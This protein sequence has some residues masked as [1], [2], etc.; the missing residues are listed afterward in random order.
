MI[1]VKQP[2]ENYLHT[3]KVH[4]QKT[5]FI[6]FFH[7]NEPYG[8][9]S[10]W[11]PAE[12][13]YAGIHFK[14]TEQFMMFHK[15]MMFGKYELAKQIMQTSD[16]AKC[17]YIAKQKFPEFNA[18]LWERTCF[19]IVKRGVRAK[20]QQNKHILDI[21]IGT[22]NALLAECSPYDRKWGIGID[23]HDDN[24]FLVRKWKGS[25]YLGMIL[26]EVREELRQELIFSKDGRSRYVDAR[27]AGSIP[28]WKMTAGELKRI[29]QYHKMILAYG[30]TLRSFDLQKC[31][32]YS[33]SLEE[34]DMSFHLKKNSFLP[35]CGFYEMKQDI[36]DTARRLEQFD[37]YIKL[38]GAY[39]L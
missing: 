39:D 2:H 14:N 22:G 28:V 20:F 15:V 23:I 30:D 10:N 12:F 17:K 38:Q 26:M 24:R 34:W 25:N 5:N 7:E 35:V 9:F 1:N 8:C 3:Q 27:N 4:K 37:H 6:G 21:L 19:V 11:Y 16:P 36:Y 33:R 31:F 32:Y 29:P 18:N 13:D